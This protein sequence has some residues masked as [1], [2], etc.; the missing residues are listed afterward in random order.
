M[1]RQSRIDAPGALHHIIAY[2]GDRDVIFRDDSDRDGFLE[3][4]A[5]ILVETKTPCLAWSLLDNHFH[6]LLKTGNVPVATVMRRLLTGHAVS[7]NRRHQRH[8]PLFRNRYKSTLCQEDTYL[9][10][11]VRYVH[12]NPIRVKIVKD[13][14][15]LDRYLYAGHSALM[16]E[17]P[18]KWQDTLG[19]LRRFGKKTHLAQK[20][21]RQFVQG[22]ITQGQRSEL[23][24]GGLVRSAGGWAEVKAK[25]R[26]GVSVNSDERILGDFGFAKEVLAAA[27][28]Q[29]EK[30]SLLSAMGVNLDTVAARVLEV[31][32]VKAD[33]LS[34][35]GKQRQRV[36]ARSLYCYWAAREL[37]ISMTKL[38]RFFG[39]T[40]G[41]VSKSVERGEK[42]AMEEGFRFLDD[43]E[44]K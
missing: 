43:L 9:V 32:K 5:A 35:P 7:F 4:L 36:R 41:A 24:G 10:E 38:S 19:V 1:P 20:A 6:L 27:G 12:L 23:T 28:E 11:L 34:R 44:T 2:G 18:R 37:G 15:M 39:I 26:A 16:G 33:D 42:L 14:D 13:M 17:V 30:K 25:R 31:L 8:G 3:R 40:V 29:M 21:Y 22:G